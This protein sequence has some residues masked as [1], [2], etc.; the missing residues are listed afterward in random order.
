M[1]VIEECSRYAGAFVSQAV[2]F[3]GR[4]RAGEGGSMKIVECPYCNQPGAQRSLFKTRCPNPACPAYDPELVGGLAMHRAPSSRGT[5]APGQP[6]APPPAAPRAGELL[7]QA[8]EGT[9]ESGPG[10]VRRTVQV[11]A[12][13]SGCGWSLALWVAAYWAFMQAATRGPKWWVV[14]AV[15]A[16]LAIRSGRMRT[17]TRTMPTRREERNVTPPPVIEYVEPFDPGGEYGVEIR[18][19]NW[20]GEEKAFVADRRTIRRKGRHLSMRVAP[21]GVRIALAID[22]IQNMP[23]IG[24]V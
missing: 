15:L 10:P 8:G 23:E 9:P 13:G 6:A 20:K 14:A 24:T 21:T 11:K 3:V 18:Y 12:K 7:P 4:V 22:R 5:D 19:K 2:S 16:F 17:T 1:G